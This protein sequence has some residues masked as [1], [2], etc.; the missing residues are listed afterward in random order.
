M[1]KFRRRGLTTALV[2]IAVA[3]A[4]FASADMASAAAWS[5]T[6]RY[7]SYESDCN[8]AGSNDVKAGNALNWNCQYELVYLP[9][10]DSVW[11]WVLYEFVD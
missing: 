2:G 8:V 1:R 5:R 7:F 11:V 3:G 4:V 6:D 9:N 10:W